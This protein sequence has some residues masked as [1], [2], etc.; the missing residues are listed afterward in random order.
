MINILKPSNLTVLEIALL[1]N[2][3]NFYQLFFNLYKA[4]VAYNLL[5]Q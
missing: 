2:L 4:C 1:F 5:R 3:T